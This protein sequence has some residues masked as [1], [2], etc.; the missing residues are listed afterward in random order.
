MAKARYTKIPYQHPSETPDASAVT[1][2]D[3]EGFVG[4]GSTVSAKHKTLRVVVREEPPE[5]QPSHVGEIEMTGQEAA[6]VILGL[7]Q[8]GRE[9]YGELEWQYFITRAREERKLG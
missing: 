3:H 5:G 9:L 6:K 7:T 4:T 8:R 2:V 1:S